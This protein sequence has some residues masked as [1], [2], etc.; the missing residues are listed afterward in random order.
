M[1]GTTEKEHVAGI[2]YHPG[3][4]TC[5]ETDQPH[6]RR[7]RAK[8]SSLCIIPPQLKVE[9]RRVEGMTDEQ[10][11]AALHICYGI[12]LNAARRDQAAECEGEQGGAA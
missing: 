11:G 10:A 1:S 3:P 8:P 9:L 5:A 4:A 7:G 2:Q 6:P 12:I